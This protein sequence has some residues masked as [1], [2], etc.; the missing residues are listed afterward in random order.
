MSNDKV[1]TQAQTPP[2]KSVISAQITISTTLGSPVLKLWGYGSPMSRVEVSGY[3]VS[4]FTFA[5]SDGY[6][7]FDNTFLP[8]PGQMTYPEL[9]LT[10]IDSE[11]RATTPTC[12]PALPI[13][14]FSY[15]V[16]PVILPPTISLT[17]GTISPGNQIEA[18]G[19]TLPNSTV[20]IVLA[21]DSGDSSIGFRL[22]EPLYAYYIPDY[23]VR[24]DG[25]GYFSL[26]L[27]DTTPK[28]WN[29]FA[30][31]DY[32]QNATSPKSNTL[33]FN[34]ISPV[35]AVVENFWAKLLSLLTLPFFIF[36]EI[37]AIVLIVIAI[38]FSRKSH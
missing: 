26:N 24:S 18:S 36:I 13:N 15:N 8:N 12:I 19:M 37:L 9:C 2:P 3:G 23:T 5:R 25:K 27:P 21:E 16:G 32:N 6:F 31:T 22:V 7:E 10:E 20:K 14:E 35:T 17:Q 1:P 30:I 11:A 34:V 28:S 4:D 38:I 33:K 29:I